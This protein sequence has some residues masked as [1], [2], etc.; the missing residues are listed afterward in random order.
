MTESLEKW[1]EE[2]KM[3][4]SESEE[5]G[6]DIITIEGAGKFLYIKPVDGKVI[7]EDF[8]FILS[9]EEY[10]CLD[11][12]KV[13]F[14][15]FEFGT[16]FYYSELKQDKSKY[17]DLIYKP[18]FKDFKYLGS[19]SEEKVFD[20]VHL[21]VHTEYELMN[22]SGSAELWCK[23]AKFLGHEAV[24]VCDKNTLASSLS[25]QTAAGKFGLK[26]IIGETITVAKDYSDKADNQELYELKLYATSEKG[27]KNLLLIN[28][29]INVDY[30]GF[31]PSEQ[32]YLLGEGIVCIIAKNSEFN[33]YLFND[34]YKS[35][36][37][38]LRKYEEVFDL[39][40]YQIDTV[41]FTSEKLFK[42]HL[43]T[44]DKYI[45][46]FA[47]KVEP[48]LINDSYYLDRECA[49]LKENL[50]LITS[51]VEAQSKDQFFKSVGDT[52]E[53]YEGW[54]EDVEP[55]FEVIVWAIQ[56]TNELVKKVNFKINT[57]ERKLPKFEVPDPEGLF[58][59]LLE[60]GFEKKLGHLNPKKQKK[61]MDQLEK[62][63]NVIVPAGIC[64][65]FLILW[66]IM[67]YCRERDI[68]VGSG[69]GSVCG[70]LVAYLLDITKID[71]L[72]YGLMFER[73]LNETRVMPITYYDV[74]FVDGT[75]QRFAKG[76]EYKD[77][78]K[79]EDC[80]YDDPF[81]NRV[82]ESQEMR[83][84]SMP[85]I[86]CDFPTAHRDEVKE[87]IKNKYGYE[88]TCSV[89]TYTR[90]KLKTCLKDFAKI[91]GLP[92]DKMNKLTKDID[93][94]IEYVWGDLIEYASRSKELFKFVQEYPD[95]VH[96][97][98]YALLLCK[99]ESVHPSAVIIVPK[100]RDNGDKIDL[101]GWM[102]VKK[103]DGVLVSEWEGK[104][105]DKAGFLKE[106]ILGLSQLDKFKN[107]IDLIKQNYNKD[108]D[109][110]KIPLDDEETFKLFRKGLCEDVFQFGTMG[111]MN[112]CRMVKPDNLEHLIAMTSLFRPGPMD[113]GAHQD[114]AD[115]KN[116][117]KKPHYDFGLKEVTEPTVGL[118]VYQEQIM[119]AVNVLGGLSLVEADGLR[120][121]MKKKDKA[122]M[123]ACSEKFI[124]GAIKKGCSEREAK[125][126]WE[127]LDKFSGYGF[128]KS[129]AAAYSVMSYW[130]EWFKVNYP[131][132]FWTTSL[133][134]ASEADIPFRLAEMRKVN[135]DIEIRPADVNFSERR[136]TCDAEN[137]RI[138]FSLGKIK[139]VG[140]VAVKNI[141]ETRDKG[142]KF[143]SL[144]EFCDRVPSKVNKSVI[145]KLI[146][147]GAFDLIEE[148]ESPKGRLR[149]LD[150]Y[151]T[152]RGED[153]PE[154]YMVREAKN[155]SFW[156]FIQKEI[157]GYG[158][159]DYVTMIKDA[160]QN[161]R[162]ANLYIEGTQFDSTPEGKEV[163][164]AGKLLGFNLRVTKK[165]DTMCTMNIDSNNAVIGVT[166]WPDALERM[167]YEES[168]FV[169]M[170][171]RVIAING[172]V[173]FEKFKGKKVIQTNDKSKLYII[174]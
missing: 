98:K 170:K 4:I 104:Y 114:F 70:S 126:I 52:I 116:G 136:F 31:I 42:R 85:D 131:L 137:N 55:L 120:T 45:M 68:M 155:D 171:N 91:K 123:L 88:Y 143:Y 135:K 47:E 41:E 103:I 15:L 14:I 21:G 12:K 144:D 149:L 108:I 107:I 124:A 78:K 23:K 9:D 57:G 113:S 109:V 75:K 134:F 13:D 95:L 74:E 151:L 165:G 63:C 24:G 162:V 118:Y 128:N 102:P 156:I 86:D 139:G 84:D 159:V 130:S 172:V 154:Q 96:L 145:V 34:D 106:D 50:N 77:G 152:R 99:A 65:Y 61:Y 153:V 10:D 19:C 3:V 89:G 161:K 37:K 167:D 115:I 39:V 110:T 59:E 40:Y 48:I 93:D 87:Y 163:T 1:I 60:K 125:E 164:I 146:L 83:K 33:E 20:F 64:D 66:D 112:Y 148:I 2:N 38:L 97:T 80:I 100:E 168:D 8:A 72:K 122:T 46:E 11:D 22:G 174:S 127:K 117:K 44:I 7:D 28:K 111:L 6:L 18:Q 35:C 51:T 121:A 129:H 26:S 158:S 29:A 17:N 36:R 173:K 62:E 105:V 53:S 32:L 140:E 25:F 138:F 73:F 58:F 81:V 141:I 16:K 56:N 92:F 133:D 150:K 147:A 71:P 82:T 101:F 43:S 30:N 76:D 90:M 79:V 169:S 157:T 142:G 49:D 132:E 67:K 94:Q 119:K 69:R 54:L 166:I 27:W 5:A 160:I